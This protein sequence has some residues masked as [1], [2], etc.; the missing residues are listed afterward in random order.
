M[1][2]Q[3]VLRNFHALQRLAHAGEQAGLGGGAS[4]WLCGRGALLSV[5]IARSSLGGRPWC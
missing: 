1:R 3:P 5:S 2:P 4:G